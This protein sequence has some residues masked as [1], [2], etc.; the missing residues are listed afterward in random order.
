MVAVSNKDVLAILNQNSK[1]R[2]VVGRWYNHVSIKRASVK[3]MG[4]IFI[5]FFFVVHGCDFI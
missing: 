4:V 2:A 1:L 3:K 5:F